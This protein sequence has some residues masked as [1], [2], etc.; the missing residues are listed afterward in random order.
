[1]NFDIKDVKSWNNRDNVEVGDKG[2]FANNIHFLDDIVS[3]NL[4]GAIEEIDENAVLCFLY[5][6]RIDDN[7]KTD[8]IA[9]SKKLTDTNSLSNVPKKFQLL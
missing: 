1:M 4:I 8:R 3:M 9:T 5:Q 7:V 6:N 2:Y